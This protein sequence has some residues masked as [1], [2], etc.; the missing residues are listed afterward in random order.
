M[1]TYYRMII[2]PAEITIDSHFYRVTVGRSRA[3]QN[4]LRWLNNYALRVGAYLHVVDADCDKFWS[5]IAAS[6]GVAV[7]DIP[8]LEISAV[9]LMK[10]LHADQ[11]PPKMPAMSKQ[12]SAFKM[13]ISPIAY[14]HRH[15]RVIH[16]AEAIQRNKPKALCIGTHSL[17][18]P[19]N[20]RPHVDGHQI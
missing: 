16:H 9:E 3:C 12:V 1:I 7:Y 13:L 19:L 2:E 17:Q 10:Q 11:M 18:S 5:K 14:F 8:C 6:L 15:S 4:A 20:D